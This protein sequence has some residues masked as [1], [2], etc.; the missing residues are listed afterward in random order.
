MPAC[1][2]RGENELRT[3][4]N[5]NVVSFETL[6][7]FVSPLVRCSINT[8]LNHEEATSPKGICVL[9]VDALKCFLCN[10]EN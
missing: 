4:N 6:E 10:F 5:G 7:K 9:I 3:E 8:S 1:D 2:N